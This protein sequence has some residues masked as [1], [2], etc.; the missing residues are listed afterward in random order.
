MR[1]LSRLR[2]GLVGAWCPSIG[3]WG[4]TVLRDLSG[5]GN[6]GTLT[7]M[8]P[9]T[10]WVV[11]NGKQ[12]LDFDGSNDFV[13]TTRA[14]DIGFLCSVSLW[15]MPKTIPVSDAILAEW[16]ENYNA[17]QGWILTLENNGVVAYNRTFSEYNGGKASYTPIVNT[18]FH[19]CVIYNRYLGNNQSAVRIFVNGE[20]SSYTRLQLHGDVSRLIPH[21]MYFG[22]RANGSTS[23]LNGQLD[24]IRIYNRALSPDEIR[25]LASERGIGLKP[26]RTRR[27]V[28]GQTFTAARLR[29]QSLIGSGV[30]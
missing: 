8:D 6:H 22:C 5:Q 13:S 7:N 9:A 17:T 27:Y 1:A 25:L 3:G 26:E 16:S 20:F 23:P 2:D 15:C 10:D 19:V 29:R 21:K 4:G 11:S 30:Y 14:F 28:Q 24:D 12:A 18:W